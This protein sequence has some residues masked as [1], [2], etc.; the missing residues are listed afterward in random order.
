[1]P[2]VEDGP[3]DRDLDGEL[4]AVGP[5]CRHLDPASE[6]GPVAGLEKAL[7]AVAV[8][9]ALGGRDDQ[10]AHLPPED[11]GPAVTEGPLR[12]GVEFEDVFLVVDGDDA[13]ER[14]LEDGA[15]PRLAE[16][17]PLLGPLQVRQVEAHAEQAG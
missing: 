1:M 8:G 11:L 5:D 17:E 14:G 13:I 16:P 9:L 4:G 2:A 12:G 6:H 10:V 7:H 15:L 3:D